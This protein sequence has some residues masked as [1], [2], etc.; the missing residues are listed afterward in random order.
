MLAGAACA[1][2]MVPL[3]SLSAAVPAQSA[4]YAQAASDQAVASFYASR[5]NAP[6]WL[7]AG[8]NS[9]AANEL[10]GVLQ[11]APLDGLTSGPAIAAQVQ[12]LLGR[13]SA[14]D[15][16]AL[17]A[18]DRLLST[19]WVLYVRALQQP[20]EGMEF[21]DGWARPRQ[22]AP[23]EI[24]LQAA[25]A[26]SLAAYVR[27]VSSPNPV[28]AQLRD[29]AWQQAQANGGIIDPRVAANLDRVRIAPF[30]KR[31]IIVDS[32]SARLFMIDHGQIVDSMKVIVGKPSTQTPMLASTIYY[33]TLNPYW[34]VPPELVKRLTAPR[35]LDQGL[36][37]LKTHNYRVMTAYSDEARL[38]D[39]AKVDWK[40]IADGDSM[41]AVR[42]LPG[43]GNSMG[44]VKYGF[45]NRYD[46]YLHDTP[47]KDLFAQASR[48]ISNGCIRL[49][50]AD[51]LGRW[52][53][54]REPRADSP[55][56]EQH[57][58]LPSPVPIYITYLTAQAD[59][60][61][62]TFLDDVYGMDSGQGSM[63]ATA[64]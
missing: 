10:I 27:T 33:A 22:Q 13:A 39:P 11:R 28:Y 4:T 40:A 29:A 7:R 23:Q 50:D 16:G 54:G 26:H 59:G 45:P 46:V 41:V 35:V 12:K 38:L 62:L 34:N 17:I 36:G 15:P 8:P 25:A 57:A 53:L 51:R 19:G 1:A 9:S 18:A 44:H 47:E 63:V 52:L 58:L 32:G 20:P 64:N 42:Q 60:G 5:R 24:L 48:D 2:L 31:Y 37:Y 21:A 30:Q 43:P 14:G 55:D 6:L 61:Q 3:L 49:E 56:P